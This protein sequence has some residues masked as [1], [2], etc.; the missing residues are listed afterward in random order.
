MLINGGLNTKLLF[1]FP[2]DRKLN[3]SQ[4]WEVDHGWMVLNYVCKLYTRIHVTLIKI[5]TNK[6]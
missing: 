6:M 5:E 1:S 2:V 4:S 3:A